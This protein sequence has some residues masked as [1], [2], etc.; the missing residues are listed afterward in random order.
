MSGS[1]NSVYGNISYALQMHSRAMQGLQEQAATGSRL[2]R[3]SDNPSGAYR[4]LG[5]NSQQRYLTNFMESIDSTMGT[6]EMASSVLSSM[7]TTLTDAMVH[8][9]QIISGTYGEGEDGQHA[10]DRVAL[11]INDVLEQM[12]ASANTQYVDQYIF[13]GENTSQVPYLVQRENGQIVSVTYQ[14]S[15][16][17]RS[18]EIV[19]GVHTGIT[20]D[21][22]QIFQTHDRSDPV[23]YG[24]TG[25]AAGTGTSSVTG[26][27]W[28]AVTHDGTNYKLSIDGGATQI[29]VPAAGDLSN[30]AVTNANGQVLYVDASNL[31]ATGNERVRV[32]GTYDVFNVLISTR[33]LLKNQNGLSE[34]IMADL[35]DEAAASFQEVKNAIISKESSI[36]TRINFL[37]ALKTN[38]DNIKF[39]SEEETAMLEEADIAQI[40]VD[41]SRR[42]ALYEMSLSV[43]GRLMSMSLLNFIK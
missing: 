5:L 38:L 19:P 34:T 15:G 13:G 16:Q 36:G 6:Q 31:T 42:E 3:T 10:R 11:E 17:E 18:I 12:V 26:D 29:T 39:N 40:A 2:N 30:I 8:L 41:I 21:G 23:F 9:T 24:T 35:I 20:Y 37:D 28:L 25:A 33:D 14:G 4:V 27:V 1:L 7:S 43:A 22:G 32:P